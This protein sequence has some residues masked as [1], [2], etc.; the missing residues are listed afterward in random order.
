MF[1][2]S[3]IVIA[4]RTINDISVFLGGDMA[5]TR[6]YLD[7]ASKVSSTLVNDDMPI[8]PININCLDP[9]GR[10][11]LLIGFYILKKYLCI[12]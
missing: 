2:H 1:L 11:A 9:L 8:T 4:I 5:T 6:R 10:N 3:S 7:M 12:I